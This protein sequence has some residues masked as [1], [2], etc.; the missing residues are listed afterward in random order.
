MIA[1]LRG[2]LVSK[3]ATQVVID[4]SGVGYRVFVPVTTSEQLPDAGV[5]AT[6]LTHMVVREDAL[7]I[8]GFNDNPQR[9]TFLLLTSIPGIGPKIALGILSAVQLNELRDMI[10]AQ[11]SLRLRKLPG[12]GPKTAERIVLELRDKI[13]RI[14]GLDGAGG[15]P[16]AGGAHADE[17]LAALLALGYTRSAAEKSI[18]RAQA[19]AGPDA[20]VELLIR[21]ALRHA[22][23]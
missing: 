16:A 3:S 18:K 2:K 17:A 15:A 10:T 21:K 13:S 5:E 20:G 22:A 14:E 4:C 23:G 19:E 11:D 8:Y 9:E 1:Q 6:I 12:V 7:D